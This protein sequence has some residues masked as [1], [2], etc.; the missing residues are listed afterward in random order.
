VKALVD[1]ARSLEDID[2]VF[3]IAVEVAD[4]DDSF[5]V[6]PD[7]G[8]VGGAKRGD[9][10]GKDKEEGQRKEEPNEGRISVFSSSRHRSSNVHL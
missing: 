7:A 3:V 6:G 4:G 9:A 2:K 1:K 5:D 10:E 8:D